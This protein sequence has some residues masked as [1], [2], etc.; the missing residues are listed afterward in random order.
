VSYIPPEKRAQ[1]EAEQVAKRD[2]IRND[3]MQQLVNRGAKNVALSH[4]DIK[5]ELDGYEFKLDQT[6]SPGSDIHG[7][8]FRPGGYS[9][10]TRASR[11]PVRKDDSID[12]DRLMAEAK[13]FLRAKQVLEER[14][15]EIRAKLAT[16]QPMMDRLAE[17]RSGISEGGYAAKSNITRRLDIKNTGESRVQ[18]DLSGFYD[19]QTVSAILLALKNAGQ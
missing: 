2:K 15:A 12:A 16:Q 1:Y 6:I 5:F 19:E 4:R 9:H 13:Q 3:V 18:F 7:Y 10:N 8:L 11:F 17:L 14:D